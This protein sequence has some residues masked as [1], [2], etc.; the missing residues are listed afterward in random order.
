MNYAGR[1][2]VVGGAAGA[3]H[4]YLTLCPQALQLASSPSATIATIIASQSI[5]SGAFSMT[6]K[7]FS[8]DYVPDCTSFRPRLQVTVRSMSPS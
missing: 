7:R 4:P 3:A 6:R 2:I 8:S 5:I 1:P